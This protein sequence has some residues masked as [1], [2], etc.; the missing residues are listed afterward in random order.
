MDL[1]NAAHAFVEFGRTNEHS[2]SVHTMDP[3]IAALDG[4][5]EKIKNFLNSRCDVNIRS[6]SVSV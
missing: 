4:D 1:N 2:R 6:V 5:V 3:H